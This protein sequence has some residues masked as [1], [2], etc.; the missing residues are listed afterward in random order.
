[1]LEADTIA[2]IIRFAHRRKMVVFADEVYQ[3]NIYDPKKKFVSF[4]KVRNEMPEPYRSIEMFSFHSTSKGLLGEC[5]IRGGY[6]E[7]SNIA[8]EVKEQL[9]K[10]KSIFLCSNSTGQ[11]M[12]GLMVDPPRQGRESEETVQKYN[13]ETS[14]ILTSMKRRA[15]IVSELLNQMTNIKCNP[16]EGAMYAFPS[17]KF[18]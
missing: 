15:N 9:L 7:M 12:T 8:P 11:L 1:M 13:H 2:S 18:S 6:V 17:I 14:A 16:V 10:L 3:E 5:G 4:R